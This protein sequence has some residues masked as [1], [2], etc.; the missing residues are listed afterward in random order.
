MFYYFMHYINMYAYYSLFFLQELDKKI[1]E[2]ET[3]DQEKTKKFQV[4]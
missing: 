4:I 2:M 3:T 1:Q